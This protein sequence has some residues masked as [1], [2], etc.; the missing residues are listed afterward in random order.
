DM[1]VFILLASFCVLILFFVLRFVYF[2]F[3]LRGTRRNLCFK[4]TRRFPHR[5]GQL[6]GEEEEGKER[7]VEDEEKALSEMINRHGVGLSGTGGGQRY[8]GSLTSCSPSFR[9]VSM[10]LATGVAATL[11]SITLVT[12]MVFI[13]IV[14]REV[15]DIRYTLEREMHEWRVESD[16]AY[17]GLASL[18]S[19]RSKRQYDGY[20]GAPVP[21]AAPINAYDAPVSRAA[22]AY[23]S[24]GVEGA[25]G[26]KPGRCN[27]VAPKEN[28]CAAGPPGTKGAKGEDGAVGLPGQPG[29]DG[30]AADDAHAQ[31][32][33]YDS[34]FHCPQGAPGP[35]G[36]PGKPGPRGMRGARGQAAIPG[37]D[38]Q[39]GFP[40]TLG[41]VGPAGPMGEEGPQGDP[42]IDVEHQVGIPGPKGPTGLPGEV[43]DEGDK[44]DDGPAGNQGIPGERGPVGE[45]GEDGSLG[46]EGVSGDEGDPGADAEYCPC[47]DRTAAAAV[48]AATV[49]Q[50]PP[51]TAAP[52]VHQAPSGYR[53]RKRLL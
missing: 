20:G 49:Q 10:P 2:R 45:P 38:G 31:T 16:S 7:G 29:I 6:G 14:L 30:A 23:G 25:P 1:V 44:G 34:C 40:G 4:L 11:G 35:P 12:M 37:R 51:T 36:P 13:P 53:K 15:D 43:G 52:T 24:L 22:D 19:S 9:M 41:E 39:P 27:C 18:S 5:R 48:E 28:K 8:S 21:A 46:A 33:Q 3:L 47:P 26:I 50:E 42:G 17:R 32:Q